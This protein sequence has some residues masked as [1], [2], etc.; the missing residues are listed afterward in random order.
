MPRVYCAVYGCFNS[1]ITNPELSYFRLPADAER[2]SK[3]LHLISRE[4]LTNKPPQCYT[5][6]EAHFDDM[7]I[8]AGTHRK[9]LKNN[10]L[11]SLCLP[12]IQKKDVQTETG[13][14]K[15]VEKCI[16]T[17]DTPR[18]VYIKMLKDVASLIF[19][20]TVC[21][22]SHLTPELVLRLITPSCPLWKA[23]E[24]ELP[25]KDPFWAFYWPGGQ[26]TARYIL[27][28][29]IIM[30]NR[31]VIDIGCGCGAGAI[32]AAKMKAEF[33][34]ANDVDE[35]ATA[36]SLINAE[37]NEVSIQTSS[38]N[39]IGTQCEGFDTVLIGDMFYDEEFANLLFDWLRSLSSGGKMVLIGDPGRHGLTEKRRKHLTLLAKYDLP[40]VSCIENHGF[41][42][43]SLWKLK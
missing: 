18:L 26:A 13:A 28:N 12:I 33:V 31:R 40:Q 23:R 5:V 8:L 4:D 15:L 30:A 21:S 32:A 34:M 19:K 36:A 37:L 2:R 27:D 17:E 24:E 10:S 39:F 42:E 29:K 43:T 6:C 41:M 20:H 9:K 35:I 7:D 1:S 3:W 14:P 11:P 16:Q 22:R 38:E 25:F